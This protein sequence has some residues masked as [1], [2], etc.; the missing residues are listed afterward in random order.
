ML[1]EFKSRILYLN[2][3]FDFG[4][5]LCYFFVKMKLLHKYKIITTFIKSSKCSI[6]MIHNNFRRVL[7]WVKQC[8]KVIFKCS[9]GLRLGN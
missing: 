1:I 6:S 9:I 3:I 8:L 2:I 5:I 7:F 4:K